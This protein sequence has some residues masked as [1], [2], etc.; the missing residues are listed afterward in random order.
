MSW[1]GIWA[2][3]S[4]QEAFGDDLIF[5]PAPDFGN[6]S[7]IGAASWQFGVSADSEHKEGVTEFIEFMMQD[8]YTVAFSDAIFNI[9]PTP[10]AAAA[11]ANFSPGA[12]FEIFF[13]YSKRSGHP[14]PANPRLSICRFNI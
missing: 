11:S 2:G 8:K 9:P 10:S 4:A 14:P 5:L 6:G 7:R 3:A 1:N 13:E 12:P